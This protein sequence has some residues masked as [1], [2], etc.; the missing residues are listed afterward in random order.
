MKTNVKITNLEMTPAI[1]AYL[2]DKLSHL[3][4]LVVGREDEVLA[5]V[6]LGKETEHHKQGDIFKAEV[7]IRFD[8]RNFYTVAREADLYAAIDVVRDQAAEELKAYRNK[9]N[10]LLRRGGRFIKNMFKRS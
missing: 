10:T 3:D 2:D 6:E 4:K 1:Q 5:S 7:N 9:K 8:G